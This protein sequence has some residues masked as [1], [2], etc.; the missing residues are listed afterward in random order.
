MN[1]ATRP[2]MNRDDVRL[3]GVDTQSGHIMHRRMHDLPDLLQPGD[4]VVVNDA[5][6]LPA[7]LHGELNGQPVEARIA[8][9][10]DRRGGADH[11]HLV[12]FGSGDWHTPT[13]D[14]PE[15]PSVVVGDELELGCG[16]LATV[17]GI[18]PL[19]S[20]L[21]R[22]R[23]NLAGQALW[24][25]LYGCGVPVQ[26]A[27]QQR[28]LDLWSVQTVYGSQP[29]AVEMP[30]AGRPLTWA[31]L[32]ALRKRGVHLAS[33]THAAGLSATGD[34]ELD[35]ALP[36]PERY[37]IP[38]RTVQ[39]IQAAKQQGGQIIAVGTSVVRALEGNQ[40]KHGHL[41]AGDDITDLRIAATFRRH[42]VDGI[43][44]G[45]HNRD[46]SHFELLGAFASDQ[47][48][49][50]SW[51]TAVEAGYLCHEFGDVSLLA[52]RGSGNDT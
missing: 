44:T 32:L 49:T 45:M 51:N 1:A 9:G 21:L 30:S 5:A 31:T 8:A 22:V 42:V 36:L 2:P 24:S 29:W 39:V 37:H 52:P 17:I 14:R 46:E 16:L 47:V 25:S 13:E 41:Q 23:F 19:S 12:L 48:L 38:E 18:S 26:Y 27:Y 43:L 33:L 20:R 35:A 3:L 40:R 10:C 34:P 7:S 11:W 15:P 28:S 4:V 50:D 6:T